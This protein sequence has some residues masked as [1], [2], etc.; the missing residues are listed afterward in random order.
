MQAELARVEAEKFK[1]EEDHKRESEQH[2]VEYQQLRQEAD[3][4]LSRLR[5]TQDIAPIKYIGKNP[6]V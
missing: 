1:V 3:N 5:G 4:E 2:N 6:D